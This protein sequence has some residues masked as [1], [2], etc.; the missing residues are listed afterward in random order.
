MLSPIL[1]LVACI[2][3]RA[4]G[5]DRLAVAVFVFVDV[6]LGV[7]CPAYVFDE[8][9][10]AGFFGFFV[11]LDGFFLKLL[12]ASELCFGQALVGFTAGVVAQVEGLEGAMPS[13]IKPIVSDLLCKSEKLCIGF[14]GT[15][16]TR[17]EY[18]FVSAVNGFVV[19]PAVDFCS[20]DV[21][22][23]VIHMDNLLG[24]LFSLLHPIFS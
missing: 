20:I 15:V 5:H 22:G 13:G 4:D 23:I 1:F 18:E 12:Q 11:A 8:T 7:V 3:V 2:S 24:G 9:P 14:D 10:F 19:Y 21:I 16:M 6:F 17:F